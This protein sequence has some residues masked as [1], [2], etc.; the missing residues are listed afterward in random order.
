MLLNIKFNGTI[1]KSPHSLIVLTD[2]SPGPCALFAFN[3]IKIFLMFSLVI[4]KISN[5]AFFRGLESGNVLAI[6]NG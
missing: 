5:L 3:P 1:R 4:S 6:I 2:M